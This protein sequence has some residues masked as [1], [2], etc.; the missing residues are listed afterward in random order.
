MDARFN[1][2]NTYLS[3][4]RFFYFILSLGF[5]I[6]FKKELSL[7]HKDFLILKS[8]QLNAV[9]FKDISKYEFCLI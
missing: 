2:E 6:S 8:L 7:C 1:F 3:K 4:C 5:P 9:D